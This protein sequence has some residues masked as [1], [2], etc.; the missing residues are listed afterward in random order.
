MKKV[1]SIFIK[2]S[3]LLLF[4]LFCQDGL[5]SVE[6]A[7]ALPDNH[8]IEQLEVKWLNDGSHGYSINVG[9][10]KGTLLIRIE[11]PKKEWDIQ[12][13]NWSISKT[14]GV[15]LFL[16]SDLNTENHKYYPP[17]DFNAWYEGYLINK[18]NPDPKIP[19]SIGP[20][21]KYGKTY[22]SG[23]Q[24]F[25]DFSDPNYYLGMAIFHEKQYNR[26]GVYWFGGNSYALK[27]EGQVKAYF[28]HGQDLVIEAIDRIGPKGTFTFPLMNK[29]MWG[30]TE[31]WKGQLGK[32]TVKQPTKLLKKLD[33]GR[34]EE[35]RE[36]KNGEEF[37]V[38]RYL[39][40]KN[41][42]YG[43]GAGMFV[44]NNA[45]SI[46]YETPSKRNLRLIRIMNGEE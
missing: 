31:L 39:N 18:G 20:E 28:Y 4:L 13:V 38:Y 35:V 10:R 17:L 32:V 42:L 9:D 36:L 3:S 30:K 43:V 22:K 23:L 11:R 33:S 37:R 16:Q 41:G 15:N 14:L 45:N 24:K 34:L 2:T 27:E 21:E 46:Q 6:A 40:E 26:D 8:T 12:W 44:E 1:F 7:T 25:S 29:V 5:N 19:P